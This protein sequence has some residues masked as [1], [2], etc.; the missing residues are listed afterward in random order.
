MCFSMGYIWI[1]VI[2]MPQDTSEEDNIS[3][4]PMS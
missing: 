2:A 4:S 1:H 3:A